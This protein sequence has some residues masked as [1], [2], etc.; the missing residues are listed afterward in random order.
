MPSVAATLT[1]AALTAFGSLS[2]VPIPVAHAAEDGA[3]HQ[4]PWGEFHVAPRVTEKV[5]AGKS[6]TVVVDVMATGIPR[7][8]AE[9]RSG[10]QRACSEQ[11]GVKMECQL[12]GPVNTDIPKQLS[13]L[14]T[15]LRSEQVD[16]LVLQPPLP[17]EFTNIINEYVNAGIPVYTFNIDVPNSHRFAFTALNEK[18]AGEVNG[19]T[20][21]TLVKQKG[22]HIDQIALGTSAPDEAWA[23]QRME[24]FIVGYKKVFPDAKFFN[25]PQHGFPTGNHY[26]VQ[27]ALNT[28]TPFLTAH[29]EVN[30]F[31][32]TD[33]GVEGVGDVIQNLKLQGKVFTSGF[34]VTRAI[35]DSISRGV[36]LV[37]IDQDY[38]L[39]TK[40]ATESCAKMVAK[41]ETPSDPL[42]YIP[43]TVITRDGAAGTSDVK[44]ALKRLEAF[45]H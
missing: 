28:V 21:A 18:Q 37:T 19:F 20:T 23:R 39:Q 41:G 32:H 15:L 24:G 14:E 29:P 9:M 40:V 17:G 4:F 45:S 16:C 22:L 13:Q 10:M 27:E 43:P 35:L 42:N 25:D 44:S 8:A 31:F 3:S 36:T 34:N 7:M 12:T 6:I 33:Q 1:A 11:K 5:K 26:S 2:M 30:L 38:P